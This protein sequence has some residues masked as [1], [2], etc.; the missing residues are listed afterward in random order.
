MLKLRTLTMVALGFF[1][2][3]QLS[4]QPAG[5]SPALSQLP[6]FDY[7]PERIDNNFT[8]II[9]RSGT[10]LISGTSADAIRVTRRTRSLTYRLR[11]T[12]SE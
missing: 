6:W 10:S 11:S 12:S 1:F 2:A 9:G 7:R 5:T 4:A 3:L 8:T